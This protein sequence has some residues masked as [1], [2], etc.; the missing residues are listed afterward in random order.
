[1]RTLALVTLLAA[2]PRIVASQEVTAPSRAQDV[3]AAFS[4][5]KHLVKEKRGVRREQYVDVRSE[6][7][8]APTIAE[9]SGVYQVVGL[10]DVIHLQI[11]SDG[12]I[13]AAGQDSEPSRS[14]VLENA[15]IEG[16]VLTATKVY[17]DGATEPFEGVFMT[18]T[19]RRSPTMAQA[20]TVRDHGT[21]AATIRR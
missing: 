9:Y 16:A 5:H 4:K 3:A 13:Q 2:T 19:E 18:R 8:V 7:F 1:M 20:V 14:F 11:G 12:T 15:R 21:G 6:P 10:G 17:R